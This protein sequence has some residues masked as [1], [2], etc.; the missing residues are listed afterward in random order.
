MGL[1][2]GPLLSRV[3][4]IALV[5][6]IVVWLVRPTRLKLTQLLDRIRSPSPDTRARTAIIVGLVAGIYLLVTAL[7][8][9]RELYP[10]FHDEQMHVLQI[11]M[12]AHGPSGCRRTRWR[13]SSRRFTSSRGRCTRRFTSRDIAAACAGDVARAADLGDAARHRRRHV[14]CSIAS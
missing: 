1:D 7:W 4:L 13:I 3:Q 12:L 14:G 6:A 2:Q 5:A 8:Q 11:R 10:K 9:G